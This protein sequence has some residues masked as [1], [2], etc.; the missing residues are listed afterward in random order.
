MRAKRAEVVEALGG[1]P[2]QRR[3]AAG[4]AAGLAPRGGGGVDF[5]PSP[6]WAV[7]AILAACPLP[8]GGIWME[9][10]VGSA[11]VVRAVEGYARH[12]GCAARWLGVDVREDVRAGCA[13]WIGPGDLRI[14]DVLDPVTIEGLP[15]PDV[16]IG[17]PPYSHA[18]AMCARFIEI[19]AGHAW[20]AMLLRLGFL[21]SEERAPFL[22]AHPPDLYPLSRRPSFNGGVSTDAAP[23]GW[24]VWP[25]PGA[26]RR[27]GC[28]PIDVPSGQLGLAIGA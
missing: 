16:I 20:V 24:I 8:A 27:I 10:N 23:Y 18:L 28:A 25:P 11:A 21:E 22:R 19:A 15:R 26:P 17:N 12:G 4:N 9:P 2:H 13:P 7:R 14:G 1:E 6:A 3:P 5:F